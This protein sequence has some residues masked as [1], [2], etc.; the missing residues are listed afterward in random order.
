MDP[1]VHRP[2]FHRGLPQGRGKDSYCRSGIP[3]TGSGQGMPD[4]PVL[5]EVEGMAGWKAPPI[6]LS[7]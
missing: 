7:C 1:D 5:S 3:S 2:D 6:H 4:T